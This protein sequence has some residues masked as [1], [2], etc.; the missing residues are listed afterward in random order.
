MAEL[1]SLFAFLS[2][3][4][5]TPKYS[6]ILNSKPISL[7]VPSVLEGYAIVRGRLSGKDWNDPNSTNT[8]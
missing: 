2:V 4:A 8:S 1:L 3:R 7:Q 6:H 5:E